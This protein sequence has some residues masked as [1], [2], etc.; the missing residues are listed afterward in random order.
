[1]DSNKLLRFMTGRL[2]NFC[3]RACHEGKKA[4]EEK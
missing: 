2:R 4:E 3:R 1:M